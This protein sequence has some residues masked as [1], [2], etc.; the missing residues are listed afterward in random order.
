MV[1]GFGGYCCGLCIIEQKGSSDHAVA[2]NDFYKNDPEAAAA[3]HRYRL[4]RFEIVQE[5]FGFWC[6]RGIHNEKSK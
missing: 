5:A 4:L 6:D 1:A 3:L 2:N